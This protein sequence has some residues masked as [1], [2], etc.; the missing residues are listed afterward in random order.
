MATLQVKDVISAR[1]GPIVNKTRVQLRLG[2]FGANPYESIDLEMSHAG[3][4]TLANEILEFLRKNPV[5]PTRAP[6]GGRPKL[7][8]VK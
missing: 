7:R 5:P 3:A 8:I 6:S 1:I 2:I 4:A